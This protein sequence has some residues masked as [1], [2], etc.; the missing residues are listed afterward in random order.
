MPENEQKNDIESL[1]KL[2]R[3][4]ERKSSG[5]R[6]VRAAAVKLEERV[7]GEVVENSKGKLYLVT[8]EAVEYLTEED[9]FAPA[10][11]LFFGRGQ[12]S[13]KSMA[14]AGEEMV[15]LSEMDP[16]EVLFLDI[17]TAGF[18]GNALFL[19][20]A[21]TWREG[22]AVVEQLFARDYSEEA[23]V[24]EEVGRL[25]GGARA[26]VT[27]NGRAFDLPFIEDRAVVHRVKL[28]RPEVDV[29]LLHVARRI[30]KGLLP[31]CRLVTLEHYVCGRSRQGDLPSHLIP[32]AYHDYVESSDAR[33]MVDAIR[34]NAYDLITM[35]HLLAR[36]AGC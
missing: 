15:R 36:I 12:V 19:V 7:A 16:E 10:M 13:G 3:G 25:Y 27:F 31:N 33:L 1:R 8:R 29:D 30:W 26:V 17:E 21:L 18:H 14:K 32:R 9:E 4:I 11:E 24:V 28:S 5:L 34:H 22:R 2:I 6:P 23:A 20:G 35:A